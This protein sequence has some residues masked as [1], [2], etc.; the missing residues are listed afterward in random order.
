MRNDHHVA[1][2]GDRAFPPS[3][4]ESMVMMSLERSLPPRARI[5]R[6][7]GAGHDLM[8]P[9]SSDQKTGGFPREGFEA[10][11]RLGK[12]TGSGVGG[13]SGDGQTPDGSVASTV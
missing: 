10:V 4:G 9:A 11:K 1:E 3:D 2:I 12:V 13:G 6:A 7:V 8:T 5:V